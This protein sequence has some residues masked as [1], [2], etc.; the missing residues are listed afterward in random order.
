M[1][2]EVIGGH[3]I[4]NLGPVRS[5]HFYHQI[6]V[7]L[8]EI[9]RHFVLVFT[10]LF[11]RRDSWSSYLEHGVA[12]NSEVYDTAEKYNPDNRSWESLPRIKKRMKLCFGCYMD[13]KF[14]VIS[15]RNNDGEL[16]CG[17]FVD[18]T[19]S[20]W[21]LIP[22]MLKDDHVRSSH[23]LPFLAVVNNELYLLESSSNQ[24]K[25]Y[26][27]KTNTWKPLGQV[28]VRAACNRGWGVTFKSLGNKLLVI[29]TSVFSC[30]NN[31]MALYTYCPY[32]DASELQWRRID[33]GRNLLSQFI[34]KYYVM[35]T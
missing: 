20:T 22:D 25:M 8:L 30:A 19:K 15:G 21:K 27:K 26:L 9:E 33:N 35:A 31:Y 10:F 18:E 16:T 7:L 34:L 2:E 23:S 6:F 3:L 29:G 1:T 17:E 4:K 28:L 32:A 14:Y 24:L 5:F 13:N 11:R 12:A